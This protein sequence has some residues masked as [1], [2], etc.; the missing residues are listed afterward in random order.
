MKKIFS[1][2]LLIQMKMFMDPD[3]IKKKKEGWLHLNLTLKVISMLNL[4]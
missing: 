3:Y 2:T 4:M 1:C